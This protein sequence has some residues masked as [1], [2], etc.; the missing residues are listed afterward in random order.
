MNSPVL[1][2]TYVVHVDRQHC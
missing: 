2:K 1:N